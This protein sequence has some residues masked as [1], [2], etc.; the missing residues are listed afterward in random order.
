LAKDDGGDGA[1][2]LSQAR[3]EIAARGL[4]PEAIDGSNE[5]AAEEL[6]TNPLCGR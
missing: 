6:H 1:R 5:P 2:R 4:M 3:P